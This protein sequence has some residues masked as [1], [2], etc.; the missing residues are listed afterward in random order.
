MAHLLRVSAYVV[1]FL[2]AR[3]LAR[4]R[5]AGR[6]ALAVPVLFVA[7]S[8]ALVGIVPVL[9][10]DGS[11]AHGTYINRNHFAALLAMA[12][13]FALL[14]A[15]QMLQHSRRAGAT[16]CAAL[17]ACGSLLLAGLLLAGILLSSSRAAFLAMTFSTGWMA[18]AG[19]RRRSVAR[20]GPERRWFPRVSAALAAAL[21]VVTLLLWLPSERLLARFSTLVE[22]SLV[23]AKGRT[24]LWRDTAAL[25]EDYALTGCG[26][27]AY[28]SVFPQYNSSALP[29][30]DD[31]AHNDFLQ[32]LA[33]LGIAGFVIAAG[34]V[35][36]PWIQ[37]FR[38]MTRTECEETGFLLLAALAA[39][40]ALMLHSLVDFNLYVPANASVFAWT[41]GLAAGTGETSSPAGR[42]SPFG[43]LHHEN[44]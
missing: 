21:L 14:H 20:P 24:Q 15:L 41:L 6:W 13:P 4:S 43:E 26:L 2:L 22:D 30:T 33:E 18:W 36:A 12:W 37:G 7:G 10:T 23:P 27:G 38:R 31:Y 44:N 1:I 5:H 19:L 40:A 42:R 35:V 17:Q 28:V 32:L 34:L 8:Q 25:I 11:A 16:F 29:K 9:I 3:D 39:A